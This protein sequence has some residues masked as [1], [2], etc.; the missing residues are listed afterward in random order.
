LNSAASIDNASPSAPVY[1]ISEGCSV[2]IPKLGLKLSYFRDEFYK[3]C[4]GREKLVG[5]T[6]TDVNLQF[7]KEMT[8]A[9]QLSYCDQLMQQQHPAVGIA[10]VFISHAWMYEFL[11]VLD[12]LEAFFSSEPDVIIWFDV[13]SVNQHKTEN[14]PFEFWSISFKSAVQDFGRTV[15]VLSPWNDPIPLTRGWCLFEV[16]STIS[17]Q[18]KFEVAM[19]ES[20]KASFLK[21][22]TY[23]PQGPVQKMFATIDMA[24][25]KCFKQEDQDRIFAIVEKEIGFKRLNAMIF[26]QMRTWM[27]DTVE[28]ERAKDPSNLHLLHSVASLYHQQGSYSKAESLFEECIE[29][30]KALLGDSHDDTLLSMYNLAKVYSAA[31]KHDKADALYTDCFDRGGG[32]LMDDHPDF[33]SVFDLD[34]VSCYKDISIFLGFHETY[35]TT[36]FCSFEPQY[37]K[38]YEEKKSSLGETHPDTLVS[39]NKLATIYFYSHQ[40]EKAEELYTEC[41]AKRKKEVRAASM[42]EPLRS[43]AL[44]PSSSLPFVTRRCLQMRTARTRTWR[45][46]ART[47]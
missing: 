42:A 4:G 20:S 35:Q 29:K 21:D 28:E 13:F 8:K 31:S 39:L 5:K 25:S 40:F 37:V 11:E 7:Q 1:N 23:N 26:D 12:A 16:Y 10:T 34:N 14:L 3:A 17:T 6:T 18:S 33:L 19:T 2:S 46:S 30:R 43:S 32:A 36:D 9:S 38:Y 45:I 15:M 24:R 27:I 47:S 44:M 41:L 22:I